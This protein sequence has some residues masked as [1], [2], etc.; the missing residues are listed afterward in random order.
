MNRVEGIR[1]HRRVL[2]RLAG[3]LDEALAEAERLALGPGLVNFPFNWLGALLIPLG[4]F[5]YALREHLGEHRE[6]AQPEA[7]LGP[8]RRRQKKTPGGA[9]FGPS[10]PS[11]P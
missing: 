1:E 11:G 2:C 6:A 8:L 5:H 4:A 9:E 7:K 3:G 10:E